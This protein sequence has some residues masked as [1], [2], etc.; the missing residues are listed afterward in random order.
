MRWLIIS[1]CLL[2]VIGF[3]WIW[4]NPYSF[5]FS[6]TTLEIDQEAEHRVFAFGTLTNPFVR[7]LVI[8]GYVPTEPGT[9]EGYRRYG[10]DLLPDEDATTEGRVFYVTATQLRRLD[11]YERVGVKYER[12]LYTLSDGEPA[13]VYRLINDHQSSTSGVNEG[14][15]SK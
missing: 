13:W 15:R 10:L 8:F 11:R 7:S 2:L 4:L 3:W 12:Y 1:I 5:K 9:L 14:Q 6:D